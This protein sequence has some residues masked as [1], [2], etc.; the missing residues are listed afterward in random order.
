[1]MS[2]VACVGVEKGRRLG[3]R[4]KGRGIGKRGSCLVAINEWD[5]L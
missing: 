4:E 2:C 3:G 1:M 5:A